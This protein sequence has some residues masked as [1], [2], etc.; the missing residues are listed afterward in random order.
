MLA[1]CENRG[2]VQEIESADDDDG[3]TVTRNIKMNA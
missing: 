3:V 2:S 1:E